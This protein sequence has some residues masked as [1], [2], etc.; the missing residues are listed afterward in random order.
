MT[1]TTQQ[2][3]IKTH[4]NPQLAE[5]VLDQMGMDWEEII[6]RPYDFSDASAGV[7]GFIYY[8][9]TVKFA[10]D[11]YEAI[12][13]EYEEFKEEMGGEV[14]HP[15]YLSDGKTAY[16][17]WMAWFALEIIMQDVIYETED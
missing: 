4:R 14:K 5:A 1:T 9:E 15:D 13:K 3:F 12:R 11:H 6:E 16:L 8:S 2:N 10:E 17:N 7:S